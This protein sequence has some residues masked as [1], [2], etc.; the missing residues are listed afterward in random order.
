MTATTAPETTFAR[1]HGF[2]VLLALIVGAAFGAG[3]L[4]WHYYATPPLSRYDHVL[5]AMRQHK[6]RCD[7]DGRVDLS[8]DFPGI[9]GRNDAYLTYRD[10]GSFAAMF[11][12]YYGQGMEITGLV[13]TSRPLTDDDTH[14]RISAIHFAQKLIVVGSYA[15][16][17]VEGKINDHWYHV[18]YKL[19]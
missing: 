9:T 19:H 15:N 7:Q 13:Y 18:S 6:V 2:T 8:R 5:D 1:R 10:D 11:P 4:W 14:G 17:L 12:T 3:F 16:L